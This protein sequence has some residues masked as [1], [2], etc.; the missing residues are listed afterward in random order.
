MIKVVKDDFPSYMPGEPCALCTKPTNYWY[1]PHDVAVCPECA[2]TASVADVPSKRDWLIANGDS[3]PVGWMCAADKRRRKRKPPVAPSVQE[4]SP[5]RAAIYAASEGLDRMADNLLMKAQQVRELAQRERWKAAPAWANVLI[6]PL[7]GSAI[8]P[9][10]YRWGQLIESTST[11]YFAPGQTGTFL[12]LIE[13]QSMGYA[14]IEFSP[15]F[16]PKNA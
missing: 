7:P 12:Q 9:G 2:K 13:G 11:V 5:A 15:T 4:E 16:E 6:G 14:I 3:L 8:D 1:E 10:D